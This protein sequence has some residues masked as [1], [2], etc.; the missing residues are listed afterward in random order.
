MIW[1]PDQNPW[2]LL[3]PPAHWQKLVADYDR[4]IR[5]FPGI[6]EQVYRVGRICAKTALMKP[7]FHDGETARMYKHR[8]IPVTSLVPWCAWDGSFLRWLRDHDSWTLG[9]KEEAGDRVADLLD[10][11]DVA[12]EKRLAE[13][14]ADDA[15]QRALSGYLG[16]KV[17]AGQIVGLEGR[18]AHSPSG[19]GLTE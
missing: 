11:R 5:I 12:R 13:Q 10:A 2:G 19:V 18:P 8:C 17:R 4:D 1:I 16:F 9:R 14:E 7:A 15:E 3:A 6:R